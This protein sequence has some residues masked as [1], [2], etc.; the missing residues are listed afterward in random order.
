MD[1]LI[2]DRFLKRFFGNR[3]QQ[4]ETN[5]TGEAG[6]LSEK[7]ANSPETESAV[8]PGCPPKEDLPEKKA[9]LDNIKMDDTSQPGRPENGSDQ[10]AT[11]Q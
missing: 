11:D 10:P 4:P 5:P 1:N 7:E 8:E 3:S 6:M 2:S 9:R